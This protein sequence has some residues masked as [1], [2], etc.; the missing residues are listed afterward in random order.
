MRKC[1]LLLF[2]AILPFQF[3]WSAASGYCRHQAGAG[4]PHFGHHEH[5]GKAVLGDKS[6]DAKLKTIADGDDD[7][8]GCHVNP[9]Q[10]TAVTQPD[11]SLRLSVAPMVLGRPI[12]DSH[13]P[14]RLERPDRRADI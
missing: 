2:L 7:C 12:F 13:I 9:A 11:F 10:P 4:A 8:I 14:H 5:Q 3:A 6:Q 1:L